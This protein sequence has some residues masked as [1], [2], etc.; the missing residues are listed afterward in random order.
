MKEEGTNAGREKAFVNYSLDKKSYEIGM[1]NS[2]IEMIA[3][4]VKPLAISPPIDPDDLSLMEEASDELSRGFGTKWFTVENLIITDIQ[5]EAFT[6]GKNSILYY[7]D[8]SVAEKYRDLERQIS[9][10]K[11]AGKY[12]GEARRNIS[13]E[14]GKLL[15][16]PMD[17]IL[18]KVDSAVRIDP[19]VLNV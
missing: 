11:A 3:C 15:G 2:F 10:L 12:C 17:V 5:S 6:A 8:D 16:Y 1:I 18:R 13:I 9:D 4:G 7:R 19:V 14:F